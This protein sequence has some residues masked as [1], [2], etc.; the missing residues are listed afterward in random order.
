MAAPQLTITP[1]EAFFILLKAREFD[2]EVERSDPDSGS[3]SE[4]DHEIAVLEDAARNPTRD[5]LVG[6]LRSLNDDAQL[7]LIALIWIGRGDF[8]LAE[9]QTARRSA[10]DIGRQ[11]LPRYVLGIPMVSDYLDEALSQFGLSY[12]DYMERT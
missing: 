3:P 2:E 6:A 10:A 1:D 4:D 11:R 9:W 12:E 5:E 8:T 7:D